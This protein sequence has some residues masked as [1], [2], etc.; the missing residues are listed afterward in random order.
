MVPGLA[1][2]EDGVAHAVQE[3]ALLLRAAGCLRLQL[4]DPRVSTLERFILNQRRLH[5]RIDCVW[6]AFQSIR[7]L[8]VGILVARITFQFSQT[9][10]QFVHEFLLLRSH[11]ASPAISSDVYV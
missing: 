10:E 2:A 4:L 8:A 1:F 5:E 7:N 9:I 11:H 3:P 6:C